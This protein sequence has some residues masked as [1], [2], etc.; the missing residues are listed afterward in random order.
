MERSYF[1]LGWVRGPNKA[2]VLGKELAF[3]NGESSSIPS[4]IITLW[5]GAS[6]NIPSGWHLCDGSNGTPD[7]RDKF[8]IGAGNKY[9]VGATGGEETH[10]LTVNEMPSHTHSLS[11]VRTSS[12]GAHSH[13][14][15]KERNGGSYGGSIFALKNADTENGTAS[16]NS[17]GS[18]T[19]TLSG[20]IGSTGSGEA[21]SI[22][23]PYYSLCYIMKL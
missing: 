9:S 23:P 1:S 2:F 19:H 14:I 4:G 11:N 7:L 21:F 8:I 15:K 10:T 17:G 5:S 13:T 12:S 3:S 18:H 6:T 16:T 22:M 20:T